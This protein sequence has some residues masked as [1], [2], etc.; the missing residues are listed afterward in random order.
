MKV[1]LLHIITTLLLFGCFENTT[2]PPENT[3][4]T[5]MT[6]KIDGSAFD[7][8]YIGADGVTYLGAEFLDNGKRLNIWGSNWKPNLS[9]YDL[10]AIDI[11]VVDPRIGTF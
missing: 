3:V 10:Q 2:T 7:I 5:Y 4:R 6:A 1:F 8:S 11:I 9:V